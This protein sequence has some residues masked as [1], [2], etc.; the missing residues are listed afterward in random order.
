[1]GFQGLSSDYNWR[2]EVI[3]GKAVPADGNP[4]RFGF[5]QTYDTKPTRRLF[6]VLKAQGMQDI[7]RVTF[8]TD[9]GEGC[10]HRRTHYDEHI[11][12][13]HRRTTRGCLTTCG[14]GMSTGRCES[15]PSGSWTVSLV[16]C[17]G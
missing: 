9:G 3:T 17:A 11:A 1:V 7:Q 13:G 12:W 4:T 10:I 5:V 2:F 15:W 8:L 6:E 16:F 14:V